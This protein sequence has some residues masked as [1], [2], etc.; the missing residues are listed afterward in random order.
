MTT[1]K[2]FIRG[3]NKKVNGKKVYIVAGIIAF[4]TEI[5]IEKLYTVYGIEHDIL[6]LSNPHD[7]PV[8]VKSLRIDQ[9]LT[10]KIWQV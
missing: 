4:D 7:P 6:C 2:L 1:G 5:E 9:I 8:D 10:S 3:T